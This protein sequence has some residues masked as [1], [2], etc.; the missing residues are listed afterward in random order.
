MVAR[1]EHE[2]GLRGPGV[3]RVNADRCFDRHSP[4]EQGGEVVYATVAVAV[5]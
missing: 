2:G 1:Q 4:F 5:C 3:E